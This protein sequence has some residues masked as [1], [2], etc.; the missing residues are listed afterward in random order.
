VLHIGRALE[1]QR[2]AAA[3]ANLGGLLA[4]S[5][6]AGLLE[7]APAAHFAQDAV[8]LNDLVEPFE[9]RFKRFIIIN[10]YTRQ[11][12]HPSLRLFW[13]LEARAWPLKSHQP[14]STTSNV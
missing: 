14:H 4:L 7:E 6:D 3:L 13:K 11:N 5:N 8:T 10:D 12:N 9:C 2:L 1:L